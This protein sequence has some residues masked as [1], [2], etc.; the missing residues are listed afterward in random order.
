MKNCFK[1]YIFSITTLLYGQI[2]IDAAPEILYYDNNLGQGNNNYN[3]M[4]PFINNND[5]N[6][7]LGFQNENY[8]N[9]NAPNQENM[10]N[11]YF[12]KGTGAY[13]SYK[14]ALNK[15][16]FFLSAEPYFMN[17]ANTSVSEPSYPSYYTD[18]SQAIRSSERPGTFK[19]LNDRQ[20][21]SQSEVKSSGIREFQFYIKYKGILTGI[22]NV[23]RWWGPGIHTS[24]AMS[25]NAPGFPHY[26]FGLNDINFLSKKIKLNFNYMVGEVG[27][28]ERPYFFTG[29]IG[30]LTHKSIEND[31]TLGFTRTY[32][33]GGINLE[34]E[35]QWT[36]RDAASLPAE[37]LLLTSKKDLW[38]TE[39]KG[40]DRWDQIMTFIVHGNFKPSNLQI[41]FEIGFNDHLHNLYELRAHWDVSAAY[42]YGI[43]KKGLF[44]YKNIIFGVE[45]LDLIQR[46]FSDHRGTT[47]TWF[48]EEIY[49][50]NTYSGRR[51]SAH[52]GADSDD[53]YFFLG[54]QGKNW[55]ILPAFNYERH[56]VVY[57]FPPEV[58]IE[59][60]LSVIYR[61]KNWIFDLYYENEY[62]ENIGFVNSNDNVWLNNPI[63][64]SIRKT[65][66]L[67]FKLQKNLYFK[68]N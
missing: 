45:Y 25:N 68:I 15:E 14:I 39:G 5:Y 1:I 7:F 19:W 16:Y 63:P 55:T 46:T 3:I 23:N 54:Y 47:A 66:T 58:K 30:T 26:F 61:Y 33:S 2:W 20:L 62:F 31:I 42:L 67:I 28:H 52:S 51:W 56:G 17:I 18:Q 43:R 59:L 64:S 29:I 36:L 8:F 44:G 27:R 13:F 21:D 48:D 34:G 9:N 11:K 32:V 57:H 24:L 60:R 4:R 41:F 10:S 22:A 12:Q 40:T 49:K 53:F 6:F 37:G 65:N 38:Y 50:S 35:R